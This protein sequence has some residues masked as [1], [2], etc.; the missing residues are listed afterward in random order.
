MHIFVLYQD[1]YYKQQK[2]EL[3]LSSKFTYS[4]LSICQ[5]GSYE[6]KMVQKISHDDYCPT[7]K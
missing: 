7:E 5:G 3:N 2:I 1:I 6:D 4:T